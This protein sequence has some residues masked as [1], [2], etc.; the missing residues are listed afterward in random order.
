MKT[1]KQ[2]KPKYLNYERSA[3]IY[4]DYVPRA[5]YALAA[6]NLMARISKLRPE[7]NTLLDIGCGSGRHLEHL[8]HHFAVEGLDLSEGL[9]KL[10]RERCPDI[11]FHHQNMINFTLDHHFEV[12]TCLFAAIGY[13]KTVENLES[14]IAAMAGHLKPGGVLFVEPWLYPERY[15]L[16]RLNADIVDRPDLKISRMFI[17]R[18]QGNVSVYDIHYL[19]GTPDGIEYFIEREE[20]GLFTHEEYVGAFEK[21]GLQ[22]TYDEKGGLFDTEHNIGLYTG[23]KR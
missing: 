18:I 6:N 11:T 16:D 4:D 23:L 5:D 13:V 14:A 15:W 22:V 17:T 20:L 2:E 21:A 1:L 9:L 7:A 8:Q 10:A 3:Y 19:V 12:I